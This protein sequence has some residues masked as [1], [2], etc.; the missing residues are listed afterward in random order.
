MVVCGHIVK[1]ARDG[2]HEQCTEPE[3]EHGVEL[4]NWTNGNPSARCRWEKGWVNTE[5]ARREE[6][7]ERTVTRLRK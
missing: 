2:K 6:R 7:A 3:M 4:E 1:Q 5:H